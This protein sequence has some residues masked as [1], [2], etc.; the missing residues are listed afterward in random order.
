MIALSFL[1]VGLL[2]V[3]QMV[4]AGLAGMTQAR[5]RTIAVQAAQERMDDLRSSPFTSLALSPGTYEEQ[6]GS[7]TLT[8]TVTDNSP[9][10]GSKRIDLTAAW[11]N[12]KG[13]QTTDL[14]TYVSR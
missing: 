4:P 9:V 8:W 5:V 13:V 12:V 6:S 10:S 1:A 14:T 3:G 2:S 11:T 7:Y